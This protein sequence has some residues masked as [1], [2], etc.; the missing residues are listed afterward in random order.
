MSAIGELQFEEN[1]Y[2]G[3]LGGQQMDL[4]QHASRYRRIH[5]PSTIVLCNICRSGSRTGAAARPGRTS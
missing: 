4:P 2:D 1:E 3:P 5:E